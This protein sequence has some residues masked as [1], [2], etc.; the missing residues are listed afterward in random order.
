MVRKK[1]ISLDHSSAFKT[2][3]QGALAMPASSPDRQQARSKLRFS[4][5]NYFRM[6]LV[7]TQFGSLKARSALTLILFLLIW[8]LLSIPDAFASTSGTR[9][10]S[11]TY[12]VTTGL[13]ETEKIEPGDAA[14]ELTT[15][16]VYDGY[17]NKLSATTSG[18]GIVSRTSSTAYD[19]KGRFATSVTNA[20]SHSETWTLDAKFGVPLTQTGPN[21]LTT[22]WQYDS[23]GRKTLEIRADGN[24][25]AFAYEYCSGVAGG[26]AVCPTYGAYV[27]TATPQNASSVKNGPIVKTFHDT[28]GRVIQTE[29]EGFSGA[30]IF[31]ETVYDAFGRVLKESRPFFTGAT[32]QW[33][34]Y[35]YD[36]LGRVTGVTLPDNSSATFAFNG[37]TTSTTNDK[38]QIETTV[39]NVRGQIASVTDANGKTVSYTYGA[40][41]RRTSITDMAGNIATSTYDKAGR[42]IASVDPDLGHWTYAYNVLGELVSQ[43]DAKGQTATMTYDTL[44][45]PLTRVAPDATSIWVYDTATKGV[46]KLATANTNSYLRTQTYDS[47]G[48]PSSTATRIDGVTET[49]TVTYTADGRL[50]RMTYPSGFAVEHVYTSLGYMN[51]LTEVGGGTLWTANVMDAE[52]RLTQATLGNGVTVW[53]TFDAARGF[54]TDVEAG[55]GNV[56]ADFNYT[57]DTLGNLT[58]RVDSNELLTEDFGYDV[59][60]RLTSYQIVGQ[61]AKTVTYDDMGNITSK[62]DTGTY[63]Y[64]ATGGARPHA[65]KSIAGSL[66]TSFLYD[67]NGNMI[68]GSGRNIAWTSFNKVASIDQGAVD[69]DYAYG[70]E[71]QRIK[72]VAP[73]GTTYY[74]SGDSALYEKHVGASVTQ[75]NEY[76]YAGGEMV[77]VHFSRSD[78]TE[79]ARYFVKDHL[80]SIAVMTDE[81]G[82]V[83]E[84]LS[85]DAW[86]KRRYSNGTDD[87]T[88]SITSATTR[89]FTGH[90]MIDDV[91]LVNMNGRIYEPQIGRFLSPD[92][93]IQDVTNTQNLNRYTYVNNNPLSYTDPSGYFFKKLFKA[94]GKFFKKFWKPLLAIAV[95]FTLQFHLLPAIYSGPLFGSQFLTGAVT[96]GISGGVS[97]VILTG[98]PKSF[99]AGFGQGFATVGVGHL[100]KSANLLGKSLAHGVVGGAF[101]EVRGGNFTSGF[102]SAGFTSAAAPYGPSGAWEGAAFNAVVGGTGSVLGGGK[103]ADGAVTGTFAYVADKIYQDSLNYSQPGDAIDGIQVKKN[104]RFKDLEVVDGVLTGEIS[105]R[106]A[107]LQE[108]GYAVTRLRNYI[109]T[110]DKLNITFRQAR[111]LES[112]DLTIRYKA[113]F[114][115][116]TLNGSYNRRSGE[117]K[118]WEGRR[119]DTLF[120]E[121]GHA[122]GL[123]HRFNRTRS[124]MSYGGNRSSGF[125]SGE[126]NELID[127]YD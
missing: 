123:R 9:V 16:Y 62:S 73:G 6:L 75:W 103:F 44:G 29:S 51:Q 68:N 11:F 4:L 53:R 57:F 63:T 96:V 82:N 108:C 61:T 3:R 114:S 54:I 124:V 72:Q 126:I 23:F 122:L 91:D 20:L 92:P 113:T 87:P 17:G 14:F 31:A 86:G 45:R 34:T 18:A 10:S 99:L 89:G 81:L 1:R 69:V 88:G 66:T 27:L 65:V 55:T 116:G 21:N 58:Q 76:L 79:L 111:R 50:D 107:P 105:Y 94:I 84:R 26:T 67:A 80:G 125:S 95:A 115:Q 48:R 37:L 101:S 2:S 97:N 52:L 90:E 25:T 78:A 43:T 5:L 36:A 56:V 30:A 59:L 24:R 117:I 112:A 93:F 33:T 60:N 118:L 104:R 98:K 19:S 85:Y 7:A 100:F 13:L 110:E 102:L 22:T 120:H 38:N 121:F 49:S 32:K 41:G 28:H 39:K 119:D 42:K 77:G 74:Y 109:A 40:F 83:T 127:A 70:P 15:T 106:C 8:L 35:A 12:N 46:G 71:R 47:L 64:A